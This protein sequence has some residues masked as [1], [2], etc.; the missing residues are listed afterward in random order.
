MT[1]LTFFELL[2]DGG[3]GRGGETKEII[4]QM[5]LSTY[6]VQRKEWSGRAQT[7]AIDS[8]SLHF[9][10]TCPL[11]WWKETQHMNKQRWR[12][13]VWSDSSAGT[14]SRSGLWGTA[15]VVTSGM[16]KQWKRRSG[17]WN[18][19]SPCPPPL[20]KLCKGQVHVKKK[21]RRP[22]EK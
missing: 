16:K 1:A 3:E 7:Q 6:I 11:N 19:T 14:G 9:S 21:K 12:G 5:S 15:R 18:S 20:W 8:L 2:S 22:K 13:R 10:W 17:G 4:W